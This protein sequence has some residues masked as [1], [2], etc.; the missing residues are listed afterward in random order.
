[1]GEAF[2]DGLTGS[3]AVALRDPARD[4]TVIASDGMGNRSPCYSS[5]AGGSSLRRPTP[6]RWSTHRRSPARL[7][8]LR[9]AEFFA[10]EDLSGPATF[11]DGVQSLLPGEM[12]I[13]EGGR[14]RRRWLTR[15]R[16]ETRIER[17]HWEDYV[18]EFAE[19][20][21]ASVRR[22]LVDLDRVAVLMSGGLDS[23]PIAAL[24][25]RQLG[26]ERSPSSPSSPS[27]VTALSWRLS[28]PRGDEQR[29]HPKNC[30]AL[31]NRH[32]VDR[33][34][35]RPPLLRAFLDGRSILI[36]PNRPPIAGSI[37]AATLVPRRSGTASSSRDSAA[38]RCIAGPVAGPGISSP[39]RG[40]GER[41]I[42]CASWPRSSV[43]DASCEPSSSGRFF[44]GCGV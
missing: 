20:L 3:F 36:L 30:T 5:P 16:L 9:L 23:T 2:L 17:A 39:P 10:F 28:D 22:C 44:P 18:E 15:P 12:L 19:L 35:R 1:M 42:V 40:Q 34:R 25:A 33:L 43:G 41:S 14:S 27:S 38:T 24:A 6:R 29:A 21:D 37:S 13:L 11:F 32:R 31:A 7:C 4:L 8:A 26:A